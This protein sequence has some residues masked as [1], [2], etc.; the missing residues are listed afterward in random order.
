M[1]YRLNPAPSLSYPRVAWRFGAD[2]GT[3]RAGC[4]SVRFSQPQWHRGCSKLYAAMVGFNQIAQITLSPD[5]S[6]GT[7]NAFV[8]SPYFQVPT[9]V[10]VFGDR[11]VAVNA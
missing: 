5:L 9:T 1:V 11:L 2:G 6:H 10:G 8:T 7:V 3:E 4:G